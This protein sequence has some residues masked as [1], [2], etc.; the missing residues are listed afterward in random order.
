MGLDFSNLKWQVVEMCNMR[1]KFLISTSWY[2]KFAKF[3]KRLGHLIEE[4]S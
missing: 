3:G 1:H 2:V 4:Y